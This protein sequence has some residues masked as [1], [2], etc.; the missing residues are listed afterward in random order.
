MILKKKSLYLL[1]FLIISCAQRSSTYDA[2]IFDLG[3]VLI[4]T[5]PTTTLWEIGPLKMLLY[6]STGHNPLDC[7][8]TLMDL[9]SS[10]EIQ[11]PN[12][13][14]TYDEDHNKLPQVMCDWLKGHKTNEEMITMATTAAQAYPF[15]NVLEKEIALKIARILFT[16]ELLIKTREITK[17]AIELVRY[18]KEHGKKVFVLSNWD[19]QSY[20]Y[21]EQKYPQLFEL[22]DGQIVSGQVGLLKPDPAIYTLLLNAFNFKAKDCFFID[23]QPENVAAANTVGIK[24]MVCPRIKGWITF[25]PDL[26]AVKETMISH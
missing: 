8:K 9:L 3:G 25:T 1:T 14:D 11:H 20:A 6:A 18:C 10:I 17:G 13:I 4:K 24:G 21:M 19:P 7:R 5:N 16:P 22:F 2:V 12:Q 26:T 23:D 15:K